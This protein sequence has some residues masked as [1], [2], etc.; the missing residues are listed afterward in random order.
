MPATGLIDRAH[1]AGLLVCGWT[2]RPENKFLPRDFRD[3]AGE[4]ARNPEGSVA[5]IR[6]YIEAGVDGF[7]TDD[8]ALGRRA[9]DG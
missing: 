8:P 6:S 4:N 1:E 5:E 7:F 2:F 3:S 9:A